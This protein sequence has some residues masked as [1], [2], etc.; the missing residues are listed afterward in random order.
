MLRRHD[1]NE[2]RSI[3]SSRDGSVVT[4]FADR[5]ALSIRLISPTVSPGPRKARMTSRPS[6]LLT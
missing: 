5:P 4:T 1:W 3:Q 6:A 2:E